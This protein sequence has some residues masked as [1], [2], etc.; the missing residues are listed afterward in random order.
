MT[1]K[2]KV[3]KRGVHGSLLGEGNKQRE[4]R[5]SEALLSVERELLRGGAAD[6]RARVKGGGEE[7]AIR[8]GNEIIFG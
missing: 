3:T 7:G 8:F 4:R 1:S 2:I 6:L 5:T